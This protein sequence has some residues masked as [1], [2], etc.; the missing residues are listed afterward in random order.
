MPGGRDAVDGHQPEQHD[1][2]DAEVDQPR[3][4]GRDGDDEAREVDLGEQ[5]GVAHE[6]Q[7]RS[8]TGAGEE[9]PGQQAA[10]AE[11]RVRARRRAGL[12]IPQRLVEDDRED[13]HRE[14]RLQHGPGDAQHRLLVADEDVAPGEEVEQLAVLPELAQLERRPA[15]LALDT[16]EALFERH[17]YLAHGAHMHLPL[18]DP[19]RRSTR[20]LTLC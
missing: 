6:A 4:H 2:G 12:L 14:E 13:D 11:D 9:V 20:T 15:A 17:S 1:E 18:P 5:V 7:S 8:V 19:I 3:E 16:Y 10:E